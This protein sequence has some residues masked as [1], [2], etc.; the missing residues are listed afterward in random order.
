MDNTDIAKRME[1]YELPSKQFLTRRTPVIIRIDGRA[2]H[3]FTKGFK[4]PFDDDILLK[5]MRETMLYLCKNI[6]GCVFG[7]TQ[8]DEISLLLIDYQEFTSDAWFDYNVQKLCSI[9]AS[10]ATTIFNKY[11]QDNIDIEYEKEYSKNG[12]NNEENFATCAEYEEVLD[13]LDYK[14]DAL[15]DKMFKATFDARAFNIPKEDV[16]NYF[17]WRQMD[18]IKNSVSQVAQQHFSS[19]ELEFRGE[20]ARKQML[21]NLGIN[22]EHDIPVHIQRGSCCY[23]I[24]YEKVFFDKNNL[25]QTVPAKK[26]V[27]DNHTNLFKENRELID[28]LIYVGDEQ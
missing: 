1:R 4:K 3:S 7:Y 17:V 2:F 11:L 10:M 21:L 22:F 12:L 19:K 9:T 8:S 6:Q 27:I 28:S 20:F 16:T 24:S 26:F 25:P 18:C 13:H 14:Y 15:Y 5:S 23:K